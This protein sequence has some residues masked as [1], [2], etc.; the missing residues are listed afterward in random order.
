MNYHTSILL[1]KKTGTHPFLIMNNLM[2][3]TGMISNILC[4]CLLFPFPMFD[5]HG[6]LCHRIEVHTSHIDHVN[7]EPLP[8]EEGDDD[9]IFEDARD[10][11]VDDND[12]TLA[13]LDD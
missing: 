11:M 10:E 4:H 12:V 3:K 7:A 8:I 9:S 2:T 5:E 13:N 1:E 6:D